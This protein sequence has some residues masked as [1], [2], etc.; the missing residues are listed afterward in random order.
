LARVIEID[1]SHGEGG[2]Q[3][4]RTAVALSAL[5]GKALRITNVRA[6]RARPGLGA[7]HLAAVRAVAAACDARCEGLE[8]RSGVFSFE[9]RA[10]PAGG[11]LRADV[12]TAGS[13]T[14]VLQALLPVLFAARAPSRVV[15]T[16]GTDVRQAPSWDYFREVLLRL[17]GRMGLR[18]RASLVRRGYYPRGGGE[19]ALEVEPGVPKPLV[20]GGG[21]RDWRIAGEAHVANLPV[22]IAERMRDAACAALGREAAI[23]ARSLG[24][25]AARG[26]GGAITAW[27][28][29]GA[30]TDWAQGEAGLLGASRIAERG[31]RA[32]ALG[33]AVGAEL[34][35][36]LASGAALDVHGADQVLVYLALAHG[37]SSFTARSVSSHAM[38]AMWLIPQFLSVRFA[39]EQANGLVRVRAA[40]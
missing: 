29:G 27:G 12:G 17:L 37:A 40:T 23:G 13:V 34:A 10:R 20:L 21:A 22:S 4:V 14:L 36:D 30:I 35:A 11:E 25:D 5:T 6:S 39:V 28:T 32:E 16:G 7:Q 38:T 1:G 33:E 9:P 2:G 8:L 19:V 26:T 15:V 31:V 3:L 24:R 18:L